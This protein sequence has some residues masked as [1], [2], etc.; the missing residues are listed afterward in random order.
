MNRK[1]LF[2]AALIFSSLFLEIP[3]QQ[4]DVSNRTADIQATF[5]DSKFYSGTFTGAAVARVCGQTD[6]MHFM[7]KKTL[8][9]EYPQDLPPNQT[10][11]DVR[12]FSDE[13]VDGKKSSGLFFVSVSLD[14]TNKPKVAWVVD[15][16]EPR[17]KASGLATVAS[18]G[19]DL[20]LTVK[21][22]NWLGEKLDLLVTC[23]P[24]KK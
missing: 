24:P 7:G 19:G 14:A 16:T 23:H 21:A 6:P 10:I 13:M 20:I 8:L 18:K 12:F 22:V 2:A 15:T 5:T 3:A 4:K 9:F 17:D 1:V 11:S